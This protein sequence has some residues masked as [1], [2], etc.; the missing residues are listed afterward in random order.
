MKP[1]R[2]FFICMIT[3]MSLSS[4]AQNEPQLRWAVVGSKIINFKA[5]K[6]IIPIKLKDTPFTTIR[7]G[8]KGGEVKMHHSTILFKNGETQTV[9]M[10]KK[11]KS[12]NMTRIVDLHG[13]KREIVKL[14]IYYSPDH[15]TKNQVTVEL[16]AKIEIDNNLTKN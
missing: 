14:E 16:W 10:V 7:L 6:A 2:L 12:G 11:F 3:M 1:L 13:G 9:P 8:F 4:G 5:D 15:L